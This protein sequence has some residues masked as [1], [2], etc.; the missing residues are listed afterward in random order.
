MS[1]QT[2]N[3]K[4]SNCS[5]VKTSTDEWNSHNKLKHRGQAKLV[6]QIEVSS[7]SDELGTR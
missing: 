5:W 6:P 7:D 2:R 3:M 4:C 1:L